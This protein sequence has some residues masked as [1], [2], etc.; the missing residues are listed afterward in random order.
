VHVRKGRGC[1]LTI[2]LRTITLHGVAGAN[3][4]HLHFSGLKPGAYTLSVQV[5]TTAGR[6]LS[7]TRVITIK[8]PR[9]THP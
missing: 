5:R 3:R 9:R 6:I 4:F 7:T 2:V 8:R 1:S